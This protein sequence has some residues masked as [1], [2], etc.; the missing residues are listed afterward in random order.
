MTLSKLQSIA[1]KVMTCEIFNPDL[2]YVGFDPYS[3]W[4]PSETIIVDLISGTLTPDRKG[5]DVER[6]YKATSK[7]FHLYLKD[8]GV[9]V[10]RIESAIISITPQGKQCTIVAD[11]RTFKSKKI[12]FGWK[13]LL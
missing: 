8:E 5:D 2:G 1:E 11:S 12:I 3:T 7:L 10:S 6:F 13:H 9:A 4:R